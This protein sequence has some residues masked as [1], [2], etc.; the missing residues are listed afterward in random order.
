MASGSPVYSNTGWCLPAV[1]GY[2]RNDAA[3]CGLFFFNG[4]YN[5][6]NA[7][8]NIG[9]RL[10]VC[11]LHFL[12]R[13]SLTAWWKY[14]RYRTGSSTAERYLERPRWQTRSEAY[15]KKKRIPV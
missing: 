5:S 2:Y 13:L 6:S 1:G 15:A 4:N 12:R 9:A 8:S 14:C 10:L 3:N 7:N 11:M